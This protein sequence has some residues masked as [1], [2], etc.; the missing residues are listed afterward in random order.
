MCCAESRNEQIG[1]FPE[2]SRNDSEGISGNHPCCNYRFFM[3]LRIHSRRL[4]GC[5]CGK[6]YHDERFGGN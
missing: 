5:L 6:R 2:P 1:V 4:D 3:L